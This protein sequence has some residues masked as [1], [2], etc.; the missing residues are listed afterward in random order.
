MLSPQPLLTLRCNQGD[1]IS[2]SNPFGCWFQPWRFDRNGTSLFETTTS[3]LRFSLT[4]QEQEKKLQSKIRCIRTDVQLLPNQ[5]RPLLL[6]RMIWC[7]SAGVDLRLKQL[8]KYG[9]GCGWKA[10]KDPIM[11]EQAKHVICRLLR[12]IKSLEEK[13]AKE[14]KIWLVHYFGCGR[15]GAHKAKYPETENKVAQQKQGIKPTLIQAK[16]NL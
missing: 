12:R 6:R 5:V 3:S 4:F 1:S 11:S 2:T 15:F 13:R 7:V 16:L 10:W 14:K 8:E 9:G